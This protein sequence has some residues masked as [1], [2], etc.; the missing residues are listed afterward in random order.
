MTKHP[1]YGS[2]T[3]WHRDIRYWSFERPDLISVWLA[4][5]NESEENGGLWIVPGSQALD[6]DSA[7]FDDAQFFRENAESNRALL[8]RRIP[9]TLNQGDVLFFT[10]AC[11]IRRAA[12]AASKRSTPPC[13]RT[14]TTTIVRSRIRARRHCL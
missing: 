6:F 9:V 8:K 11:Y 10:A 4:L 12:I 3:G 13:S 7:R 14:A 5:G 1:Y 2:E